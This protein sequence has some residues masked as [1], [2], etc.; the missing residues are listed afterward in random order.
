MSVVFTWLWD[1]YSLETTFDPWENLMH[2]TADD[3]PGRDACRWRGCGRVRLARVGCVRAGW[4]VVVCGS[5]S[6]R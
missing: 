2:D 4:G 3:H 5:V 1:G 6:F